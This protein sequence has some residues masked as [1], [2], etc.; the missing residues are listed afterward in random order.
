MEIKL[1]RPLP[2]NR[3]YEQILNHKTRI[4]F[5]LSHMPSGGAE[6]QT[7]NLIRG[8]DPS[9]FEITLLLYA[10]SEIFYKEVLE[11][12]INLIVNDTVPAT[13]L[14]RNIKNATFLRN[15]LK[16]R[17]F[18]ILHT[19]LFHNGFWVRILAPARYKNRI[20][21]SI[22]NSIAQIPIYEKLMENVLARRSMVVT[23]SQ[24]VLEQYVKIV[25]ER[26][27]SRVTNIYNG[28]DTERFLS[29][30]APIVGK[31]IIIGT[32]GRQTALKNQIQILQA[33]EYISKIHPIHFY[34]VGDKSQDRSIDNK[35]FV[36][37]HQLYN[38]VTLLDS[39]N[40]IE[41]YY[42]KFNVFVLS[43]I[44]ESCPNALLEAL[45]AKCLCIVSSRANSDQ[46]I[47]DGI[48][49]LVYD[50]TTEKLILKLIDA[51]ELISN[52][53]F[54]TIVN[55]GQEYALNNFALSRMIGSYENAYKSLME[56]QG[57]CYEKGDVFLKEN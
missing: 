17:D 39:Q 49:G 40:D 43:S 30:E 56:K 5:I 35:R 27:R 13:K 41:F 10:N 8:L 44:N 12:P 14:V 4:C 32:V 57:N 19:L 7:I 28:I 24:K 53:Q 51:I 22:R 54:V 23:N 3:S 9:K 25:G 47:K 46:F 33:I 15:A 16:H 11:L 45:L 48:N 31:E 52:N 6:R 55:N 20:L 42:R 50:G 29:K 37:E 21:Y 26:H 18:D 38:I 1:K 2:R 36:I 34:L